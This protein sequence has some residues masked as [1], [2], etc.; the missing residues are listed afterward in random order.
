MRPFLALFLIPLA[1][2]AQPEKKSSKKLQPVL[3]LLHGRGQPAGQADVIRGEWFSAIE[4][5]LQGTGARGLFPESTRKFFWYADLL[6]RED[7]C[8]LAFGA[9]ALRALGWNLWP[10][11]RDFFLA[12]AKQ[13]PDSAKSTVVDHFLP[14]TGKY[15]E[16]GKVACG[17]D[18]ALEAIWKQVP[19]G[20]PIIAIAHSMG[21]IVLYKN[22]TGQL[23]NTPDPVYLIT[24]GSMIAQPDVQ[25]TILGSLQKPPAPVPMPVKWWRNIV[26][27]GD[28]L[29]FLDA[30]AFATSDPARQPVDLEINTAASDRHSATEY[31]ESDV[32]GKALRAAYCQATGAKAGCASK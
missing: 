27:R 24:I 32:M 17:V 25:A 12:S 22:L 29:A 19:D 6:N 11:A 9:E 23:R 21:S 28:L 3:L 13:L 2:L 14:D 4:K 20:T 31:L 18:D 16:N 5:G 8:K 1:A 7:A 30:K 15:L 26:N 10:K